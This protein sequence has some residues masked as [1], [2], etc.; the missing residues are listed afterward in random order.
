[1]QATSASRAPE[2]RTSAAITIAIHVAM[3]ALLLSFQPSFDEPMD[4]A[5]PL[6]VDFLPAPPPK[7]PVVEPKP[8]E[9]EP[10]RTSSTLSLQRPGGS[11]AGGRAPREMREDMDRTITPLPVA[12]FPSGPAPATGIALDGLAGLG[13]ATDGAGIGAGGRG[14]GT[15]T[16]TGSGSGPGSRPA[17]ASGART[18]HDVAPTAARWISKPTFD[19]ME[20]HNPR[21]AIVQRVSGTAILACRVDSRQR[22]RRCR[23]VSET[24]RGYGF[25]AAALETVRL[26]RIAPVT[27]GGV[28]DYKAWVRIP[29]TFRNCKKSDLACVDSLD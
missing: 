23:I 15:G 22:A 11:E 4:P 21:R 14:T 5:P 9:E 28:P 13:R 26:G 17:P 29:I 20:L 25:G 16:G 8:I 12:A 3:L 27:H 24:P 6:A 19:E 1:M 7:A 2:R 10:T 18:S